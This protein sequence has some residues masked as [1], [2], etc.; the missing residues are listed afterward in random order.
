[1]EESIKKRFVKDYSLPIAVVKEPMFSYFLNLYDKDFQTNQLYKQLVESIQQYNSKDDFFQKSSKI[2]DEITSDVLPSC[3]N[4]EEI[5]KYI[6]NIEENFSKKCPEAK[7]KNIYNQELDGSDIVSIDIKQANFSALNCIDPNLILNSSSYEEFIS[8]YTNDQYF[9][10]SKKIRQIIFS[11]IYMKE[12]I[13]VQRTIMKIIAN[14]LSDKGFKILCIDKDEV[15]F[16]YNA[17]LFDQLNIKE[18]I[19]YVDKEVAGP[20][21]EEKM[22]FKIG[23]FNLKKFGAGFVKKYYDK[24]T[25]EFKSIPVYLFAQHYKKWYDMKYHEYDFYFMFENFLCE[26]QEYYFK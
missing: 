9:I 25:I 16:L 5:K 14:L 22:K 23:I 15:C 1:M 21:I 6:L 24:H 3:L 26:F 17:Q 12:Q 7:Y 8:N 19:E 20:S 13:I 4:I 2:I 18:L 11:N 10:N